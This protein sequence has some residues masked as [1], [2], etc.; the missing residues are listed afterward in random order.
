MLTGYW[1]SPLFHFVRWIRDHPKIKDLEA[2]DAMSQVA[3]ELTAKTP[4]AECAWTYHFEVKSTKDAENEFIDLWDYPFDSLPGD[5]ALEHAWRLARSYLSKIES[6]MT[7]RRTDSY[8]Q[9]VAL[10]FCLQSLRPHQPI[11]LPVGPVSKLLGLEDGTISRLCRFAKKDGFL[12]ELSNYQMPK[13]GR[14]G[15]AKEY[16]FHMDKLKIA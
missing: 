1:S 9:Y 16:Q 11:L 14:P 4:S 7:R 5:S 3:I 12:S 6:A 2:E 15:R 8:V 13:G 10:A